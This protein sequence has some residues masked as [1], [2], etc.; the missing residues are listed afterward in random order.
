MK[1]TCLPIRCFALA[2]ILTTV[3]H[4]IYASLV[5]SSDDTA[6]DFWS[7]VVKNALTPID[8]H[9]IVE[10]SKLAIDENGIENETI[11][12]EYEYWI[13]G[14]DMR[15][16]VK[17]QVGRS[18][19]SQVVIIDNG[20]TVLSNF[21]KSNDRVVVQESVK[22]SGMANAETG[23]FLYFQTLLGR[24]PSC[25]LSLYKERFVEF[26]SL[27]SEHQSAMT[28]EDG[29]I[30]VKVSPAGGYR[31]MYSFRGTEV[32]PFEVVVT[33]DSGNIIS[34]LMTNWQP[35]ML[36]SKY[37]IAQS[38]VL[39]S[40]GQDGSR[41]QKSTWNHT[42]VEK[43]TAEPN[44]FAWEAMSLPLGKQRRLASSSDGITE[45]GYWDGQDFSETPIKTHENSVFRLAIKSF[46]LIGLTIGFVL[47]ILKVFY[48]K[49]GKK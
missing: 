37:Q 30:L 42:L 49:A 25:P 11:K 45:G 13:R 32:N 20:E 22:G 27:T 10:I 4:S 23:K 48:R 34:R 40:F 16:D 19:H 33:D 35:T 46:S 3:S 15:Y 17:D 8:G 41:I 28:N 36:N 29:I 43:L 1:R 9:F 14:T 6:D 47:L 31:I 18:L 12:T 26:K 21:S 24:L 44:P 38:G 5:Y 7:L 2:V 39:E